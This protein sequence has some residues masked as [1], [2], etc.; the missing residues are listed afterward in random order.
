MKKQR[1]LW[2][3]VVLVVAALGVSIWSWVSKDSANSNTAPTNTATQNVNVA[4]TTYTYPGQDGKNALEL[5]KTA[6][7]NTT[8]KTS[9]LGEYVTAI[10][11][12]E[13]AS[14]QGWVYTVNGAEVTV[15]ADKYVTKSADIVEWKLTSF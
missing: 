14:N 6:Y 11:G 2:W 9:S 10:N 4:P 8:T 7:P 3:L 5:L 12:V 13:A 1:S 15:G